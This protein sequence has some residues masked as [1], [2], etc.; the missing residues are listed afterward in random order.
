MTAHQL[1]DGFWFVDDLERIDIA[2]VH[3]FL[4]ESYWARGR[5]RAQVERAMR[6]SVCLAIHSADGLVAHGRVL[7]DGIAV[8]HICDV[9]VLAAH[10]GK[11]LSRMLV[12]AL[13]DRPEIA[14]CKKITLNTAD[15]HGVYAALGFKPLADPSF[16]MELRR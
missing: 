1:P 16:S 7:T 4:T 8:A 11:G 9:F 15:A 5:T 3:T 12:R 13:L 14:D 10:R 6:A 2:A